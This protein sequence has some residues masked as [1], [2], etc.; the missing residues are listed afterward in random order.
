MAEVTVSDKGQVV[1]P[2]GIRKLLGIEPGAR[3]DF[4]IEGQGLRVAVVRRGAPTT[5]EEGYGMLVCN[6]PG[7]RR[8]DDFD[9]ARTMRERG[10]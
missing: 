3:L 9:V 8:L 10:K 2:A 5:L 7:R 6:R 1:I 4:R